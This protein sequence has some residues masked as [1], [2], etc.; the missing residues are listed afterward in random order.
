M[1]EPRQTDNGNDGEKRIILINENPILLLKIKI[2]VQ[3]VSGSPC[4]E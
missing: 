2:K 3:P 4:G 1:K